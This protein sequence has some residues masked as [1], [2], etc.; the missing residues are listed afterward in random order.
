MTMTRH[1]GASALFCLLIAAGLLAGCSPPRAVESL[2]VLADLANGTAPEDVIRQRRDFEVDGRRYAADLYRGDGPPQALLILLPGVTPDGK[3]DPRLVAFAVG[4]A[5]ADFAVLVPD[6][7]SFRAL[8]VSADDAGS[9]RDVVRHASRTYAADA[10]GGVAVAAISYAAGPA[11]LALLD[12]DTRR[13]VGLVVALGGYHDSRAVVTYFTTGAYRGED[14]AWRTGQPNV[15]GKWVFAE[16][17]LSRLDDPRDRGLIGVIA[18]RK[19]RDEAASIDD[20]RDGLGPQGLAVLALLENRDP[21]RVPALIDRLPRTVRADLDALSLAERDLST[22]DMPA[23]LL[24][25]ADDP[26][27]P[28]SESVALAAALPPGAARLYLV[29]NFA[30][31]ESEGIGG[32]DAV[33]M[34]RAVYR[35]LELRDDLP[36]PAVG[37]RAPGAG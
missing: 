30:H 22:L 3:D 16:A 9:V 8:T 17:N 5:A 33:T 24:H 20:L 32:R 10:D 21:D 19:R 2:S 1:A 18:K 14:G 25:G 11:L 6:F 4:L 28:P 36:Q 37:D 23:I 15:W 34:W 31:V 29:D 12:P 35:L 27:I 26:V 13:R 7:P